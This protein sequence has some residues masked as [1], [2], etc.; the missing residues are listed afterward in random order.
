[1][2]HYK[3]QE[4]SYIFEIGDQGSLFFIIKEGTVQIEKNKK[5]I[6]KGECFGELA[7]IYSAPRSS[8]ILSKTKCV[9]WGLDNTTFRRFVTT[10]TQKHYEF[11]KGYIFRLPLFS[12]LD[13]KEKDKIIFNSH[14]FKYKV[15]STIFR[16]NDQANA[17]FIVID[18]RVQMNIPNKPKI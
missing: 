15:G 5:I 9:L 8:S 18:G 7:M 2:K 10:I 3:S 16:K 4:N 14:R 1:M 12:Y 17:I 13:D 11:I 6:E